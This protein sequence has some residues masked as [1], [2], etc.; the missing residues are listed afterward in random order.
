MKR[1]FPVL[2]LIFASLTGFAQRYYSSEPTSAIIFTGG[3]TS[4]NVLNDSVSAS[5]P[6]LALMGGLKYR[7]LISEKFSINAGALYS[8]KGYKREKLVEKYRYYYLDI[9]LYFQYHI[10]PDI[11]ID[12]GAQYSIFSMG[13]V[14][15]LDDSKSSGVNHKRIAA[16]KPNDYGLLAGIN[17]KMHDNFDIAAQYYLSLSA[18]QKAVSPGDFSVFSLQLQ[19]YM[20]KFYN[21]GKKKEE[22]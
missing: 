18:F 21:A 11:K 14:T 3:M 22:Q 15:L 7:Y 17:L 19:Y 12:L 5:S 4:S 10:V 20:V 16:L 13:N 9:P 6:V 8:G 2:L 1:I